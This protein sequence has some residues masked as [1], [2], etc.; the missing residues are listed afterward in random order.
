M[1]M[2]KKAQSFIEFAILIAVIAIALVAMRVY[3]LRSVQ[4]KFR[5]AGD[6]FGGGD[7]YA[8]GVT[9]VTE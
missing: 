8:P 3:F 6:V 9:N 4:G 7:Q 5:E 1:K 2:N